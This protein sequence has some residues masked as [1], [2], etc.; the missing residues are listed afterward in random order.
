MEPRRIEPGYCGSC[1]RFIGPAGECPYCGSPAP[2]RLSLR[3]LRWGAWLLGVVGLLSLGVASV[4]R[5]IPLV[6]VAGITPAMNF[7]YVRVRGTVT[8]VSS[9]AAARGR[10]DRVQFTVE[11]GS[12]RIRVSAFKQVASRLRESEGIP[13]KGA[14][15]EVAGSLHVSASSDPQLYLQAPQHLKPIPGGEGP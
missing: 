4:R 13:A 2:A 6:S 15:V 9:V 3:A 11:D 10:P 8:A 12:G 5:E 1:A 14:R 7:G